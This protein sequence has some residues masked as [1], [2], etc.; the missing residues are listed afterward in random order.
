M[1]AL[2]LVLLAAAGGGFYFN[3]KKEPPKEDL[4]PGVLTEMEKLQL[5]KIPFK[6]TKPDPWP[7]SFSGDEVVIEGETTRPML[8][9]VVDGK[10]I[11]EIN[12]T[13]TGKFQFKVKASD[14]NGKKKISV[15]EFQGEQE[16]AHD[17][18]PAAK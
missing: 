12:N 17:M 18:I 6:I 16:K 14:L 15:V 8:S 1:L 13:P 5:Q 2:A 10:T 7:A 11:Q 3:F 9:L 4:N